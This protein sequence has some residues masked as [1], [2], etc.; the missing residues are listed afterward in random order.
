MA[1]VLD[2]NNIARPVLE[3]T[4]QDPE[5][6][7]IRVSTPTEALVQELQA[8]APNLEKLKAGDQESVALAYD[9]AARLISCN[10]DGIKVTATALRNK[11]RMDLTAA[12]VFLSA[13][14][15]FINEV[16]NEKN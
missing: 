2:L 12:A 4:L 5:R 13:Y 15:E 1:R 9:F 14:T 10:L 7:T 6:T 11:Y 3:L 16:K 8:F